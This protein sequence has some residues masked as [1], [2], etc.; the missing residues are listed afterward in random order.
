MSLTHTIVCGLPEETQIERAESPRRSQSP[1]MRALRKADRDAAATGRSAAVLGRGVGYVGGAVAEVGTRAVGGA[2][3]GA[4]GAIA[5]RYLDS[6]RGP[7]RA[8]IADDQGWTPLSRAVRAGDKEQVRRHLLQ[9]DFQL[10]MSLNDGATPLYLAA[11][12]GNIDI[13]TLLLQ[14]DAD[15]DA[16]M[17]NGKTPLAIASEKG[18]GTVVSALL[19]AGAS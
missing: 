13:V 8:A 19:Q 3:V 9:S 15:V 16:P 2:V 6:P 10:Y 17:N 5:D 14:A 18:H 12:F 7:P 4:G 11:E 1:I